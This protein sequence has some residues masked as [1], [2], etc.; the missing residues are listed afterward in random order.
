MTDVNNT[1]EYIISVKDQSS[2][3]LSQIRESSA[4]AQQSVDRLTASQENL[5]TTADTTRSRI[6][7]VGVTADGVGGSAKT[8]LTEI[9]E[10]AM[11][12]QVKLTAQLSA[13]NGLRGALNGTIS[14][15]TTLGLL[16]DEEA[17]KLQ[18]VSS[19]FQLVTSVAQGLTAL[20]TLMS[21]I[22]VQSGIIATIQTYTAT[23]SNPAKLAIVGG[24]L[25]A[26]GAVGGYMLGSY[27]SGNN[28][29]NNTTNITVED[30]STNAGQT[31]NNIYYVLNGGAL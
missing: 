14:S 6:E 16:T 7:Q 15:M 23:L 13:I 1:I 19:A 26:A 20:R 12:T 24:A 2:A 9:D 5:G 4:T 30:T 18:N 3:T 10:H 21:A 17:K 11:A 8:T 29:T 22:S 28:T 27:M 25:G 31:A